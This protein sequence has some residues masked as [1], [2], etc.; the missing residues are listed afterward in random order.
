VRRLAMPAR[1]H[2]DAFGGPFVL[3]RSV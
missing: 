1:R 2:E 3:H